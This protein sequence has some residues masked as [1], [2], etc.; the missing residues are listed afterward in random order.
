MAVGRTKISGQPGPTRADIPATR[1]FSLL[2]CYDIADDDRRSDVAQL[3]SEVGV[4]VQLSVFECRIR[5]T[6]ELTT[7][8]SALR[9]LM[10]RHEDQIR[11]YNFG[12][13]QASPDILGQREL[14][15]WRDFRII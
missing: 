4:R 12:T 9:S 10:D 15:E 5:G 2:A 8:R 11:I 14:E 6:P 7:L 3:L 1:L 13:R